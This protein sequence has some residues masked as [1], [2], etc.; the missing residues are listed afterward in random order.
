M[1]KTPI[2]RRRTAALGIAA[3]VA[4]S[5]CGG[6]SFERADA[7]D[8][9]VADVDMT[10]AQA[11]CTLDTLTQELGGFGVLEN[12][13]SMSEEEGE[14]VG[15]AMLGCLLEADP[16]IVDDDQPEATDDPVD[17]AGGETPTEEDT[18]A[19]E[20]PPADPLGGAGDWTAAQLCGL[21]QGEGVAA[22]YGTTGTPVP[23]V[24]FEDA[25][26][27][28]CSWPDP[29]STGAVAS[30]LVRLVEIES[31]GLIID[32][33]PVEV[34]GADE[35]DYREV[36][37]PGEDFLVVTAG[38]RELTIRYASSASAGLD[39]A[40]AAATEWATRQSAG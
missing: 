39:L 32:G 9:L 38:G 1:T 33:V 16:V 8:L 27:S 13:D 25:D 34:P 15:E 28:I 5:A 3:I 26:Q 18:V 36:W 12:P 11:D 2:T 23:M 17:A 20:P 30:T 6:G 40:V 14:V 24:D 31:T 22:V 4:T 21:M 35:V 10:Q 7:I 19:E 29:D 37:L